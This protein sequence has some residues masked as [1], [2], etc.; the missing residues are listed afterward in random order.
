VNGVF[1]SLSQSYFQ[2]AKNVFYFVG[3][4]SIL[5]K[6]FAFIL[7]IG[8]NII[9]LP[10]GIIFGLFIVLDYLGN[11]TDSMRQSIIDAMEHHSWRVDDSLLSFLFRPI[12]V[13][14]L[15]PLFIISLIIPKVSSDALVNA[16]AD[17]VKQIISGSGAFKRL[18]NIIW[19]TLHR[20]FVYIK[21]APLLIK[22]IAAI[23]AIY[24]S[25]VLIML[26]I[27]FIFLIPLDWLSQLVESIRQAIVRFVD[28][29]QDRIRYRTS[30]FLFIPIVL[31]LLAPLFLIAIL[32][33]K[34]SS[35]MTDT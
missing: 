9:L 5:M 11:F 30:S 2:A 4:S 3:N 12:I 1:A 23:V 31:V 28:S 18:N 21:N 19:N 22:P 26:G 16:G 10:V 8:F 35:S 34:F 15:S 32:I 20:L 13:V 6:P 24:Y 14:I 27:L 7:A 29:S 25:M 33:P 17:E